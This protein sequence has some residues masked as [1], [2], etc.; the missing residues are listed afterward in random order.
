LL[1]L[2]SVTYQYPQVAPTGQLLLLAQPTAAQVLPKGRSPLASSFLSGGGWFLWLI[3][4]AWGSLV[5]W[6]VATQI[7]A[8]RH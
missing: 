6:F 3:L 4:L 8:R 1:P 7:I 2:P 5:V